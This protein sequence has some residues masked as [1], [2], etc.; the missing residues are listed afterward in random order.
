MLQRFA[1]GKSDDACAQPAQIVNENKL[2][3]GRQ[4]GF[5]VV[6]QVVPE[7]LKL[8]ILPENLL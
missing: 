8:P 3:G 7:W 2:P 4:I 6:L 5:Y 1:A